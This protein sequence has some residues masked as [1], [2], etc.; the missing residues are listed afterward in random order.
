M[1]VVSL[2][3]AATEIVAALGAMGQ[4][5]GVSHECDFP[6]SV[7]SLPRV[8]RTTLHP[9]LS[10]RAIDRAMVEAKRTV[11]EQGARERRYYLTSLPGEARA[12][13]AAVRSHW[14]VENGLHWVLDIAFQEDA[15]RMR[16]DHSQQ[17]FVV[18]RHMALNL[19]KQEPTATCG[20]KAR[21]LKAGWSEA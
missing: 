2:L 10:S 9:A 8:T 18:L 3:P 5:V 20:I 7:R 19:L 14:G 11:G 6:P 13:G 1:R 21:R 16:I 4:L 12:F 15:S 17:N